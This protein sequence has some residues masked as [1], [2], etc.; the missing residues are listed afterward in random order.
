MTTGLKA[1]VLDLGSVLEVVDDAVFPGPFQVRHGL[2]DDAV[3]VAAEGLSGDA[4]VG[5]VTEAQVRDHWQRE[6]AL[7]DAAAE[8]LMGDFWR[9]YVGTLDREL[10]DWFS[11]L[12]ARGLR[13]G[14]LSNSAPGAREAEACWGL[15][16][17]TDDI[18]Y[19]HE[20]GL[21][22][23]D[24][25]VFALTADRLGVQPGEVVLLDDIEANVLAA[26]ACGWFG[27]HHVETTTSIAAIEALIGP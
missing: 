5:E 11:G 15:E 12:R 22:K 4:G 7:D 19:S 14:I 6:L 23:P 24:P 13:V 9:W 26:R 8:E 10:F 3:M 25:A 16:A 18:V 21:R 27:V 2:G 1:V 20:V 17:V